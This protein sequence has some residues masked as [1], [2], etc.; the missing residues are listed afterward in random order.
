MSHVKSGP[1][2]TWCKTYDIKSIIFFPPI[3][4]VLGQ[5]QSL[6]HTFSWKQEE[7]QVKQ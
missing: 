1:A 2:G 3:N 5:E 4:N 7:K 6:M